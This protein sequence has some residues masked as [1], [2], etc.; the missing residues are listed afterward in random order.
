MNTNFEELN[1]IANASIAHLAL[2]ARREQLLLLPDAAVI[3]PG[4][5]FILSVKRVVDGIEQLLPVLF[6][7]FKLKL[8][9]KTWF[10]CEQE[11]L[12]LAVAVEK[13]RYYIS[14]SDHY[15]VVGVDSKPVYQAYLLI[16]AGKFSSSVRMQSFL[17]CINRFPVRIQHIS[18][19]FRCNIPADYLSRNPAE[20][21]HP[22]ECQMCVFATEKSQAMLCSS[23]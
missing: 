4:I 14:Q 6:L 20:C 21:K 17:H 5:G 2:P 13:S 16:K 10:A 9:Q 11:A 3:F 23:D 12:G 19:K 7:S 8:Y 15:T 1:K 18:G 22:D